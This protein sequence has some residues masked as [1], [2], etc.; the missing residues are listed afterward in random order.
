MSY[1]TYLNLTNIPLVVL[2]DEKV[3]IKELQPYQFIS[4][5]KIP[6]SYHHIEVIEK[7]PEPKPEKVPVKHAVKH[8][9]QS[10]VKSAI[11]PKDE[12]PIPPNKPFTVTLCSKKINIR[13]DASYSFIVCETSK[14][15]SSYKCLFNE[16]KPISF[17][18]KSCAI[19]IGNFVNSIQTV[20][21]IEKPNPK[22]AKKGEKPKTSNAEEI[23]ILPTT[24]TDYMIL[25]PTLLYFIEISPTNGKK[26]KI[27]LPKL[28]PYRTYC[29]YIIY[30]PQK[31]KYEL[32]ENIERTSYT[33]N[34]IEK[35]EKPQS[36]DL[37]VIPKN[38]KLPNTVSLP[39]KFP[40][41]KKK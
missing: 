3:L 33:S 9:L 14:D 25:D 24:L 18:D 11:K 4:Y 37:P 15:K 21:F 22:H 41:L 13:P 26:L 29:F 17:I 40:K 19:R 38:I 39:K 32:L 2:L 27:Q 12:P 30:N 16:E 31:K 20:N 35:I 1:V 10:A 28:K 5:K 34:H 7:K 23:K 8:K 6:D 36:P